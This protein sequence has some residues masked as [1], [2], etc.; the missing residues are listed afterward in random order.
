MAT[1]SKKLPTI[2]GFTPGPWKFNNHLS[3]I[4]SK[5]GDNIALTHA[6]KR[7]TEKVMDADAALIT[8]APDL[9][10]I[11]HE[12]LDELQAAKA[13]I[14]RLSDALTECVE[15]SESEG[16]TVHHLREVLISAAPFLS[17]D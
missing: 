1:E 16:Y 14:R 6:A 4:Q 17:E 13:A 9:Y 5:R 2:E 11:A 3:S 15:E 8:A 7:L 10:R 12:Q